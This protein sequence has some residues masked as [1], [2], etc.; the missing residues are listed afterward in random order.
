[1]NRDIPLRWTC[2]GEGQHKHAAATGLIAAHTGK[3]DLLNS[4]RGSSIH[5][6]FVTLNQPSVALAS[7]FYKAVIIN[8]ALLNIN[9]SSALRNVTLM[10][11]LHDDKYLADTLFCHVCDKNF[12]QWPPDSNKKA[13]LY[14]SELLL[15]NTVTQGASPQPRHHNHCPPQWNSDCWWEA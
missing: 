15:P 14:I 3:V 8:I 1:M 10:S 13:T 9:Y 11:T 6:R 4:W 5:N 12:H 7:L 2:G